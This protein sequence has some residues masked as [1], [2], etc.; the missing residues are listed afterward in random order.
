MRNVQTIVKDY[1]EAKTNYEKNILVAEIITGCENTLKYFTIKYNNIPLDTED[2]RGE[3]LVVLFK[4]LDKYT[5]GLGCEFKTYL[6]RCIEQKCNKLYRDLSRD[7]RAVKNDNGEIVY[8]VSY[9]EL[10][11]NGTSVGEAEGSYGDY[12]TIE[13]NALLDTLN[14]ATE[15]R[16]ICEEFAKGLKPKEIA[17]KLGISPA[18]ITYK[19]KKIRS[20]MAIGLQLAY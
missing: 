3:L 11:E 10:L 13:V 1:K 2:L 4:A 16:L 12:S 9:D 6:S 15:E 14:L 20:K 19:T 8:A 18:M 17:D 5:D 7:K